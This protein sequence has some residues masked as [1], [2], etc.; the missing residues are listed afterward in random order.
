MIG[1]RRFGTSASLIM[2]EPVPS[3]RVR[4]TRKVPSNALKKSR[5]ESTKDVTMLQEDVQMPS[6]MFDY[7]RRVCECIYDPFFGFE[8]RDSYG[9]VNSLG[10]NPSQDR[11]WKA[12]L[13]DL[14]DDSLLGELDDRYVEY[15][16]E[17][18]D[19]KLTFNFCFFMGSGITGWDIIISAKK[20]EDPSVVVNR[21]I[22]TFELLTGVRVD[23]DRFFFS[24]SG[25]S[26]GLLTNDD[27]IVAHA[28]K[29]SVVVGIIPRPGHPHD[30][31]L[32]CRDVVPMVMKNVRLYK[33]YLPLNHRLRA[34]AFVWGTRQLVR[35]LID[36][37]PDFREKARSLGV[38][39]Y[40]FNDILNATFPAVPATELI[41]LELLESMAF[42]KALISYMYDNKMIKDTA[43]YRLETDKSGEPTYF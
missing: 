5:V 32:S 20:D 29:E 27:E 16:R 30:N 17:K 2:P 38:R 23:R 14:I 37:N 39:D 1:P 7:Y 19:V 22:R 43:G 40:V 34:W 25:A 15:V 9:F 10:Y 13:N 18:Y 41:P 24:W 28:T 21:F 42:L 31:P 8:Y 26:E 36:A 3:Q 35:K 6:E 33:P 12:V 11:Y 4:S